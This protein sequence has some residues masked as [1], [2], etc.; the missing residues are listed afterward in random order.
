MNDSA[1]RILVAEDDD[2]I[3]QVLT[4]YLGAN[5]FAAERVAD[6]REALRIA[7]EQPPSV[8][9]L[10]LMLPGMDG[11]EVCRTLRQSSALPV[12]MVT[13]RVDEIDRLLGLEIGAD[14]YV[15]KP[16]SPREVIARLRALIRRAEGHLARAASSDGFTLDDATQ[17]VRWRGQP[18]TLTPVEYRLLRMLVQQP[19]RVFGRALL[20]DALHDEFRDVNDRAIDS[21]I[22]NLRKKLAQHVPE[23][24]L[25]HSVYGVGYRFEF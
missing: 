2:K 6:G 12:M 3:A 1:Y 21:H 10:D 8:L 5:G 14:D 19:G 25:I 20:L 13:A 7:L 24:E 15:C 11:L 9:V 17:R 4:D 18:L 16:F 23:R 22:K